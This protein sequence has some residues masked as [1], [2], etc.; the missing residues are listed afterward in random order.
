[1][2]WYDTQWGHMK[3]FFAPEAPDSEDLAFRGEHIKS[4]ILG[5]DEVFS[6]MMSIDKDII[7][8]ARKINNTNKKDI[9]LQANRHNRRLI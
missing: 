7:L 5:H 2:T 6:R 1:L 4:T 9:L 3:G 8:Q